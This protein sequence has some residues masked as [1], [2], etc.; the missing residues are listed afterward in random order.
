LLIFLD[1][2]SG[3]GFEPTFRANSTL[4]FVTAKTGMRVPAASR[5]TDKIE[6][7]DIGLPEELKRRLGIPG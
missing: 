1:G 2:D 3:E 4:T 7:V 5:Y 6:I